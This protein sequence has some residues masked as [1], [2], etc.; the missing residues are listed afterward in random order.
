MLTESIRLDLQTLVDVHATVSLREHHMQVPALP[1]YVTS[2]STVPRQRTTQLSI[3]IGA[4]F[5]LVHMVV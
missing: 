2:C 3:N 4:L 1:A 5:N